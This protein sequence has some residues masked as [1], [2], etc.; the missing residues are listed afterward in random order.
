MKDILK[1][2]PII[3]LF[4]LGCNEEID[5]FTDAYGYYN[6]RSED[7]RFY[8]IPTF[9]SREKI[10]IG[11]EM[12]L[13]NLGNYDIVLFAYCKDG[14]LSLMKKAKFE[15]LSI[16]ATK[17]DSVIVRLSSSGGYFNMQYGLF[18]K[19][20]NKQVGYIGKQRFYLPIFNPKS[21]IDE[22]YFY[23]PKIISNTGDTLTQYWGKRQ[24]K[25]VQL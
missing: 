17:E 6:G 23:I 10:C 24:F 7:E 14:D 11:G 15:N 19:K 22:M 3:F 20:T 13:R 8:T 16:G 4:L 25:E 2:S 12:E 21:Y 9:A 18:D 5:P 1:L